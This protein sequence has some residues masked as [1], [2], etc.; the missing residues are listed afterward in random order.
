MR[1]S[2]KSQKFVSFTSSSFLAFPVTNTTDLPAGTAML[3]NTRRTKINGPDTSGSAISQLI[4]R[5]E[6]RRIILQRV[7]PPTTN[8]SNQRA[9]SQENPSDLEKKIISDCHVENS[10]L[11]KKR[12]KKEKEIFLI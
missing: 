10:T 9:V 5:R 12:D 11:V 4:Y 6:P 2:Q 3:E 7:A 8:L 1:T